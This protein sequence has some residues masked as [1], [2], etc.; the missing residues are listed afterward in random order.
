M[1]AKLK[2]EVPKPRA[3]VVSKSTEMEVV[4]NQKGIV[5]LSRTVNSLAA[6]SNQTHRN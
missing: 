6:H 2:Q 5:A 1:I 3:V 4:N